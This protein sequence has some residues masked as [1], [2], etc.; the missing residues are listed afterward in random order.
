MSADLGVSSPVPTATDMSTA[1]R[2]FLAKDAADSGGGGATAA[3][4]SMGD[5][6]LGDL[7]ISTSGGNTLAGLEA[8]LDLFSEHPVLK[9]ILDQVQRHQV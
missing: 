5:L 6:S 4:G 1:L 7:D 3:D 8:E 9:A 2:E